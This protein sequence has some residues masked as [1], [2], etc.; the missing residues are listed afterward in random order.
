MAALTVLPA[1]LAFISVAFLGARGHAEDRSKRQV[2]GPE[3]LPNTAIRIPFTMCQANLND[4]VPC[5]VSPLAADCFQMKGSC[6]RGSCVCNS[7]PNPCILDGGPYLMGRRKR[8][9]FEQSHTRDPHRCM[10]YCN[11]QC[12][13]PNCLPGTSRSRCQPECLALCILECQQRQAE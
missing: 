6:C 10:D 9:V 4:L 3:V 13:I 5:T 7:Y 12:R 2:V 8:A 11:D 1:L